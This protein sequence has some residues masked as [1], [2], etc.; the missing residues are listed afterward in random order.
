MPEPGSAESP[1]KLSI[2]R[3]LDYYR[4]DRGLVFLSLALILA[5]TLLGVLAPVPLAIFLNVFGEGQQEAAD[6]F[7]YRLFDWLPQRRDLTTVLWLAGVMLFLKVVGELLRTWQAQLNIN[8]GYRGRTRVQNDLFQKLQGLS[9][10]YHKSVPQGDAIYRLSYD[11][12]GFQGLLGTVSGWLINVVTLVLMLAIM[13]NMN[14]L[15]TLVA[16]AVVPLLYLTIARWGKRLESFNADQREADANVTT[17]IQ[18]SLAT[19][20]LV[21]AY[22]REA[23]E[24]ERFATSVRTYV[25]ASLK[26]HWQEIL[27]WLVLGLILGLGTTTLFAVGG[28][29]VVRDALSVGSLYL[30]ISYLGSLYDPLNK[31]TGSAAGLQTAAV[32]VRRVFEVLDRDPI[33]ATKPGAT[34]LPIEPRPLTFDGVSFRYGPDAAAVLDEVSFTVSP[35]EMIAF[36]GPSGVGKTTLLNLLPRFYDPTAGSI[37]LGEHDV[38]DLPLRDVRGHIALVLQ[39]NP[40]LPATVAENIAYGRPDASDG[41]IRAAAELAGAAA[42]IDA[43]PDRYATPISEG[44]QN[45]SGGQRQRIA[46]ARALLTEAPILV[47]DEPT[48]ALDAEHERQITQTLLDLKRQRTIIVVSHRLSTVLDADRLYV[49]DA[50]RVVEEG[51]HDDLVA[52]RGRYWS[53]ARHQLR[54]EEPATASA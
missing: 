46:I 49:M 43:M 15:L 35:G 34:H 9:L 18:R 40:I 24:Q 39:E 53:M 13:L 48:S 17:Q 14:W 41:E 8:I 20:G 23:D 11:T 22:R 10:Q 7:V 50:G 28:W 45:L 51:R 12:H 5:M 16:L 44:G 6:G 3:A 27:Y 36:V 37:R 38:R 33:I 1:P 19:V 30:F 52:R 47:L 21:Q 2:R 25:D 4:E 42:F 32:Q 54:L 31:L 26:L 29:M